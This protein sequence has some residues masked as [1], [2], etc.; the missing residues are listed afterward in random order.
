MASTYSARLRL[1]L[2]ASGEQSGTWGTKTN[3]NLGTLI[4]EAI[5]GYESIATSDANVTLTAN[6]GATDQARKAILRF[7]GALTANRNVVVPTVSKIYYIDNACTGSFGLVVKTS[8]GSGITVPNGFKTVLYCDGTNVVDAISWFSSMAVEG[9]LDLSRS[10]AGQIKFP[11][12][13]NASA[14]ANTLDDYEEG[15]WTPALT[16]VTPGNL[17]IAYSTQYGTY[18]KKGREVTL[19]FSITTSTFTHTTASGNSRITGLPFACKT[20]TGYNA[21]GQLA[22]GGITKAGYTSL[23]AQITSALS[24]I[25]IVSSGSGST[26]QAADTSYFP[27]GG[28]VMLRG[29]ITYET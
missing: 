6:N 12:T 2:M 19:S 18:T 15:T 9:L 28:T 4:E 1:E 11:A 25:N 16:F 20:A 3:T 14:D 5:A 22:W 17:S 29:T 23:A 8:A 24:E 13:Q 21:E 7:T 27:T 10:T 26:F